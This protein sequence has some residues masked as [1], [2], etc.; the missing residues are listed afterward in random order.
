[1]NPY[2]VEVEVSTH[3]ALKDHVLAIP[4]GLTSSRYRGG[5][6]H[7]ELVPHPAKLVH[8]PTYTVVVVSPDEVKTDAEAM[9]VAAQMAACTSGQMPTKTTL[10]S[11]PIEE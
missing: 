1:V 9:L 7:P 11:W 6:D 3:E 2:V 4:R 5:G 8:G 10:I